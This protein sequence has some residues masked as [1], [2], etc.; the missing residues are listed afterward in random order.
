VSTPL[1]RKSF[2][3]FDLDLVLDGPRVQKEAQLRQ[4]RIVNKR[5]VLLSNRAQT[6]PRQ[7]FRLTGIDIS[8]R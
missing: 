7:L 5:K 1:E 2:A 8:E 4:Q 6:F 3:P